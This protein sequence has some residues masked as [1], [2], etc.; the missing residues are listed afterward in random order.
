MIN[1]NQ[2]ARGTQGE[3]QIVTYESNSYKWSHNHTEGRGKEKNQA[4]D[5]ESSIVMDTARLKTKSDISTV[6]QLE[7]LFS[8]WV[9]VSNLETTLCDY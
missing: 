2:D 4:S 6:L 8:T 1:V 5:L 3:M 7:N 9:E